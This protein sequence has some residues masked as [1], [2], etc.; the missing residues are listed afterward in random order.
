LQKVWVFNY[1]S[2]LCTVKRDAVVYSLDFE[3]N[4]RFLTWTKWH[5]DGAIMLM[6]CQS[7]KSAYL[8]QYHWGYLKSVWRRGQRMESDVAFLDALNEDLVLDL[9][10]DETEVC[11]DD[12]NETGRGCCSAGWPEGYHS[13]CDARPERIAQSGNGPPTVG[14]TD[15]PL[16]E[17][18]HFNA[19]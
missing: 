13:I 3:R 5:C 10:N 6:A 19:L 14:G 18:P 11:A 4:R 16:M 12:G 9:A 15:W 7:S 17:D 8:R 2:Y 1:P